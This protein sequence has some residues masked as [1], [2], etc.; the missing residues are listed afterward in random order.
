M[1]KSNSQSANNTIRTLTRDLN[2]TTLLGGTR[3]VAV[4]LD[5]LTLVESLI[6]IRNA[7]QRAGETYSAANVQ[8]LLDQISRMKV[9]V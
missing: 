5:S 8:I 6:V 2:L 7:A 4:A 1:S 3:T 9:T